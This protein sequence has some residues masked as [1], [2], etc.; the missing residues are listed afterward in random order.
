[1]GTYARSANGEWAKVGEW[2]VTSRA[3]LS[4]GMDAHEARHEHCRDWD[5]RVAEIRRITD[6]NCLPNRPAGGAGGVAP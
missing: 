4:P 1:M 3:I 2:P 6:H 5:R